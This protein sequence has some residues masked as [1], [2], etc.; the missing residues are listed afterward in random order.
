MADDG[1]RTSEAA[2]EEARK[3]GLRPNPTLDLDATDVSEGDDPA[4]PPPRPARP[5]IAGHI[6]AAIAGAVI[7]LAVLYGL[8]RAKL[9]PADTHN[10]QATAQLATLQ[11]RLA[12]LE[13]RATAPQADNQARTEVRQIDGALADLK[14]TVVSLQERVGAIVKTGGKTGAADVQGLS[15][16]VSQLAGTVNDL[17]KQVQSTMESKASIVEVRKLQAALAGKASTAMLDKLS[18]QVAAQQRAMANSGAADAAQTA[19][20]ARASSAL[21]A[22]A[23]LEGAV[24]RGA[25]Y[26]DLLSG[27]RKLLPGQDIKPLEA[28]A[29]RGAPSLAALRAQL[30]ADLA[31]A[32]NPAPPADAGF[33][34]RLAASA[35][36]LVRITPA[37]PTGQDIKGNSPIAQRARVI[38]ALDR[39]DDAAALAGWDGLDAAAKKL[40][41]R[42]ADALRRRLAIGSSID[43][44]RHAALAALVAAEAPAPPRAPQPGATP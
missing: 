33:F 39:G 21:A 16:R 42:A 8:D 38:A 18:Q 23:A 35:A 14:K 10:A 9:L 1:E 12:T 34:T 4:D 41:Q 17:V 27:I 31:A 22:V 37:H 32:P 43:R 6:I 25:P 44:L 13:R 26:D 24:A 19:A 29:G 36:A 11:Q 28:D 30:A 7:A 3:R 40:S 15:Q 5:G 2:D 20:A